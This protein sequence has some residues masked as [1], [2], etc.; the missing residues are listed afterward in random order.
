MDEQTFTA[1]D[2]TLMAIMPKAELD[3]LREAAEDA[4]LRRLAAAAERRLEAGED[5]LLPWDFAKRLLAGENP[6]R[7]WR[8]YRGLTVAALATAAGIS[9]PYLTQIETGRR[10]GTFKVMAALARALRIDLDDLAP[11]AEQEED[12]SVQWRRF[13]EEM[14]AGYLLLGRSRPTMEA[15]FAQVSRA[16]DA[17]RA[18]ARTDAAQAPKIEKARQT[19]ERAIEQLEQARTKRSLHTLARGEAVNAITELTKALRPKLPRRR[20]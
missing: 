2:G 15:L 10:D 19:V 14:T 12:A 1:P 17:A 3:A 18:V 5:E 11:P 4:G 13:E 6:V 9:Q 20:A 16:W 7:L 8:E